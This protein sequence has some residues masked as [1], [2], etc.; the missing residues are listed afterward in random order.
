[1]NCS[2]PALTRSNVEELQGYDW[3]GNFREL[4]QCLRNFLIHRDYR[5]IKLTSQPADSLDRALSE[6]DVTAE[7]LLHRYAR[8]LYRRLGHYK[9]VG[10]VMG[11]DQRTAKKYLELNDKSGLS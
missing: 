1:M 3:P 5:P 6:L 7:A 4:E 2:P 11:V 8:A 9:A 10:V